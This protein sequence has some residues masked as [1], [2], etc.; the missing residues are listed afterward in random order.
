MKERNKTLDA[1]LRGL[2]C[3]GKLLLILIMAFPF[4]WMI[5]FLQRLLIKWQTTRSIIS[6]G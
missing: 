4:F 2:D 3:V 1:G 6:P 5:L